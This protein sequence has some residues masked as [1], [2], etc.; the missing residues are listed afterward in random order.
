MRDLLAAGKWKEANKETNRVTKKAAKTG[1]FGQLNSNKIK[2]IPYVD[3]QIIDQLWVEYSNGHFG[4]S[5]QKQIYLD[6]GNL[7][8]KLRKE[9]Y[10]RFGEK[11]G[12][13]LNRNWGLRGGWLRDEDIISTSEAPRGHLPVIKDF[14]DEEENSKIGCGCLFFLLFIVGFS[15]ILPAIVSSLFVLGIIIFSVYSI[16]SRATHHSLIWTLSKKLDEHHTSNVPL[17]SAS[18]IDYTWLRDL[19]AAGEWE[20][21]N[22]ETNIV[23]KKAAKAEELNSSNLFNIPCVDLQIIDELWAKYSNGHFGFSVQKQIYSDT[24]NIPLKFRKKT[25]KRFGEKV[26]WKL[27]QNWGLRGGWLSKNL[28]NIIFERKAPRGH[29][30]VIPVNQ[31]DLKKAI[32]SFIRFLLIGTT[33][34][35]WIYFIIWIGGPSW[36]RNQ[37]VFWGFI[38]FCFCGWICLEVV[39]SDSLVWS[40][41]LIYTLSNKLEHHTSGVPL[42]SASGINYTKLHDLLAAGKWEEANYE[43]N[44]VMKKAAKAEELNTKN[45]KEISGVDL[46]IIDELW[47]KY[48][49]GHFGFSVQ[50]QVYLDT[51][52]PHL[53]FRKETYKRFGEKVGWKLNRNWGLRNGWLSKNLNNIIFERK[54]PRGHLPVIPL[55]SENEE[56]E[57]AY[58]IGIWV[59]ITVVL[60][61]PL[62]I[63]F[64]WVTNDVVGYFLISGSGLLLCLWLFYFVRSSLVWSHSLICTLS[65]KLDEHHNI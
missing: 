7:P 64:D 35:I 32:L 58:I 18:G 28:N 13:K 8:L 6:T 65:Q 11:V 19:L 43:T 27:K 29:L 42:V 57:R 37:F 21:A 23:M 50:K 47:A 22:K 3:L 60:F 61:L 31:Y 41:N 25:Y 5:V 48:S 45:I 17:V 1:W 54:A 36:T 56:D 14:G 62:N 4:F 51:G 15:I 40:Y 9:T 38:I 53:K 2:E 44:I 10:K 55:T 52:N 46:Q 59:G 63:V 33:V 34:L 12:W 16:P 26:G 20:E 39:F 30:P 24:R 49:N